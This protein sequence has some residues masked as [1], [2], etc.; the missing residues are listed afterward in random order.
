MAL[1]VTVTHN[2]QG[3]R[4]RV[5]SKGLGCNVIDMALTA[6]REKFCQLMAS[7]KNQSDAYRGAFNAENMGGP[8]VN[9]EAYRLMQIPEIILRIEHLRKPI[10]ERVGRTLEQHIERMAELSRLAL[11]ADEFGPSIKAEEN[12]GKVL[13]YYVNKTEVSGSLTLEQMTDEDLD[14]KIAEKLTTLQKN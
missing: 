8:T 11:E 12:V 14:K 6:M 4:Q 1:A 9:E 2:Q 5:Y 7:G 10:A 3:C 13:G